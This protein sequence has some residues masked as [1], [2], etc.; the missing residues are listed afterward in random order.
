[1]QRVN[2]SERM[3]GWLCRVRGSMHAANCC[4][5]PTPTAPSP[6]R[7]QINTFHGRCQYIFIES[8]CNDSQVC[9]CELV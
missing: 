3:L 1:V 6:T 2:A 5:V 4:V 9:V 8:I 7:H